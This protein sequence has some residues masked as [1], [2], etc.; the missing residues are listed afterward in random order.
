MVE[1]FL[2]DLQE[3]DAKPAARITVKAED[4]FKRKHDTMRHIYYVAIDEA[5]FCL[6]T[7]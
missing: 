5:T 2:S 6:T 3:K 4:R 7:F 1:N